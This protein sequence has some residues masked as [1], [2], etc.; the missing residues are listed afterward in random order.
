MPVFR[1]STRLGPLRGGAALIAALLVLS[2]CGD[3][4]TKYALQASIHNLDASGLALSV[5]GTTQ[6][7]PTGA[8]TQTL[9]P[10]LPSGTSYLVQIATQ[11]AT[12]T[13][14]IANGSGKIGNASVNDID[15]SCV[16]NAYPVTGTVAGLTTNGL[17]L[18]DNGADAT[19]ISANATQYAMPTTIAYG[20]TY[21]ITVQDQPAGLTCSAAGGAGTMGVGGAT[22]AITCVPNTYPVS[23]TITGLISSGLVLLDN[24]SDA[25]P[26]GVNAAQFIMPTPIAYGSPYSITIQSQPTGVTCSISGG[27]GTMGLGGATVPVS[28]ITNMYT[29][30]G[31][32]SGLTAGGLVLLDNGSDASAQPAGASHFMMPTPIAYGSAYAITVQSEPT[33]LVCSVGD[34]TGTMGAGAFAGVTIT[35]QKNTTV[36][37]FFQGGSDGT[38]P[39]A[40]LLQGADGNFYGI[41]NSGGTSGDGTIFEVTPAGVESVLHTFSGS[42]GQNPQGGLIENAGGAFFGTTVYGGSSGFG[43]AFELAANRTETVLHSFTKGG[44]GG[45]PICSL[46]EDGSGNLYGTT[47]G[48]GLTHGIVFK[49]PS[50]GSETVLH[51]FANSTSDGG[52]PTAG[53]ILASDGNYYGTTNSGGSANKGTVFKITPSGVETLLYA[54]TGGSDGGSP[55]GPLIQGS[56][57]NF[58]GTTG[59]GGAHGDGTVFQVTSN[60]T[61]TVMYSFAGGTADGSD[62]LAGLLQASDGNFYGTTNQGG[63][64]GDGTVFEVTP[65]GVETV[66]YSFTGGATDGAAPSASLIEGSDGKLYGTTSSGGPNGYGTVFVVTLH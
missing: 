44:D 16:A 12:E 38:D 23:G 32:I 62:P 61:E 10:A 19:P 9:A 56:D 17:V 22:V 35:C 39:V 46:A 58:Y 5:D 43:T 20:A 24:G 41:T 6:T 48:G 53:L 36:L 11:P 66:V 52:Y 57:G 26:I 37:Y 1:R 50:G 27:A 28:C 25:T 31:T 2:G 4:A 3:T 42:D 30:G 40:R 33:G 45:Y 21:A 8:T 65:A 7:V 59:A 64:S 49:I 18:L 14:A 13:C 51:S 54:F 55:Q 15:V 63:S 60:G 34:G 47:W 29:V